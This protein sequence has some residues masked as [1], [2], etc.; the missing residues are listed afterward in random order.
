MHDGEPLVAEGHADS[1]FWV[2]I[3]IMAGAIFVVVA[4]GLH[5]GGIYF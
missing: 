1:A 5:L 2:A 3:S 4:S